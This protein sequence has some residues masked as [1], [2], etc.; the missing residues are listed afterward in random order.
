MCI[1]IP[2]L[3]KMK[4]FGFLLVTFAFLSPFSFGSSLRSLSSDSSRT[5]RRKEY[6][7]YRSKGR[8]WSCAVCS[9]SLFVR[10]TLLYSNS[11][12]LPIDGI[13][14][15][16]FEQ[17]SLFPFDRFET[18]CQNHLR[19]IRSELEQHAISLNEDRWNRIQSRSIELLKRSFAWY[20]GH[21]S[22][23]VIIS[24]LGDAFGGCVESSAYN[25]TINPLQVGRKEWE[26]EV[27]DRWHWLIAN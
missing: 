17:A 22:S 7:S 21:A 4:R 13:V 27:I 2:N 26:K 25:P 6:S 12:E 18:P 5:S 11:F 10:S 23:A 16:L 20:S 14:H 8:C 1:F 3:D 15:H 9:S 24:K 19:R